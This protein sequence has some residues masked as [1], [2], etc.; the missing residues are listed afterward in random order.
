[1]GR[2]RALALVRFARTQE[3]ALLLAIVAVLFAG[4]VA[5]VV[6]PRPGAEIAF[7]R[8]EGSL[9]APPSDSEFT[10]SFGVP[11]DPSASL[12]GAEQGAGGTGGGGN[13]PAPAP[14]PGKPPA[15]PPPPP[16]PEHGLLRDLPIPPVPPL[17]GPR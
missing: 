17:R 9:L 4:I 14:S 11:S 3:G 10:E 15:P 12:G 5:A 1:M 13:T 2:P 7:S 6:L 16:P 8:E